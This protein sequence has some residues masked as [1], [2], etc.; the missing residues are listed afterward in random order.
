MTKDTRT[1]YQRWFDKH[2]EE[3]AEKRRKK[4]AGDAAYREKVK[5]QAR[6]QRAKVRPEAIPVPEQYTYTLATASEVVG[7]DVST[8]REWM[9]KE[10]FP[11][12]KMFGSAYYFTD[13]QVESLVRLGEFFAEHG[14]RKG[15]RT[16]EFSAL[17]DLIRA[18]W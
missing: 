17:K 5:E 2:K 3:L 18:N 11:R 12:P 10:Y 14:A 13:D 4:Y 1:P 16:E 9:G 8:L 6:L 7:V 15:A